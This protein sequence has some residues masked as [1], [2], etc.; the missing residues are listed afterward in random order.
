V[1]EYRLEP[2]VNYI[3]WN[4]LGQYLEPFPVFSILVVILVVITMLPNT[5]WHRLS[6]L[7][8]AIEMEYYHNI[9]FCECPYVTSHYTT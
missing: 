9:T 2:I 8:R 1:G 7:S 4:L 5:F 3:F 6:S